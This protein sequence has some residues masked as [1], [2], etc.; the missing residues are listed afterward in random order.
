M[1]KAVQYL[2]GSEVCKPQHITS[3]SSPG[4]PLLLLLS[5][6]IPVPVTSTK[7]VATTE[8]S[9]HSHSCIPSLQSAVFSF[10]VLLILSLLLS[11]ALHPSTSLRAVLLHPRHRAHSFT[12]LVVLFS[13]LTLLRVLHLIHS[14][15]HTPFLYHYLTIKLLFVNGTKLDIFLLSLSCSYVACACL[16][17][18]ITCL[19]LFE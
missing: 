12:L 8:V 13:F 10:S 5:D 17:Y 19:K 9:I 3:Q 15:T 2:V 18:L 1:Q 6:T 16:N 7:R 4:E 14:T 11:S